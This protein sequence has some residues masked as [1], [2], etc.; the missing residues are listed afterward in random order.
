MFFLN[1]AIFLYKL[2]LELFQLRAVN[3]L[4]FTA[5]QADK[6]VVMLM[7]VFVLITKR[8]VCRH[9]NRT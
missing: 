8:A 5:N 9:P 3:F 2:I 7:A 6:M 4:K 1:I